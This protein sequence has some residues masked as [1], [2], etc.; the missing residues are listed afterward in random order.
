MYSIHFI[1]VLWTIMYV[2]IICV[3]RKLNFMIQTKYFKTQHTMIS[4]IPEVLL[5]IILCHGFVSYINSAVI[6]SCHSKLVDYYL[7]KGF[8]ILEK[9]QC[10]GQCVCTCETRN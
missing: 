7:S 6:L 5:N 9:T 10:L 1:I 2:I 4:G 8:I 3:V